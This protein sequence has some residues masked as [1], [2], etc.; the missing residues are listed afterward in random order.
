MKHVPKAHDS[1]KKL[2]EALRWYGHV[3]R[4][5]DN[6]PQKVGHSLDLAKKRPRAPAAHR[7]LNTLRQ[8]LELARIFT[9]GYSR[10]CGSFCRTQLRLE[11]MQWL[12]LGCL[13]THLWR[14]KKQHHN[15]NTFQYQ[16]S[17]RCICDR[18]LDRY[19]VHLSDP[20][21]LQIIAIGSRN[22]KILIIFL[23][24]RTKAE[25]SFVE[26]EFNGMSWNNARATSNLT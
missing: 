11:W 10:F 25:K 16:I 7:W 14:Q 18:Q 17:L 8:Y 1:D 6:C 24:R 22:Q 26:A 15:E 5:Q 4:A 2:R 12:V 21:A 23:S 9:A 3:L 20:C 13:R 19:S